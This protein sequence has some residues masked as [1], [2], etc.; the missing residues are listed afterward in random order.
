MRSISTTETL[1][2]MTT[3]LYNVRMHNSIKLQKGVRFGRLVVER[4]NGRSP[5]KEALWL[6]LCDCG[7]KVSIRSRNLRHYTRS[8]G[9]LRDEKSRE[10]MT[11]H[12][13]RNTSTYDTWCGI[14]ARCLN[15]KNTAYNRYGGR[16]ILLCKRWLKFDNFLAD[17]GVKPDGTSI[18]RIDNSKGYSPSN[19][20]WANVS[21]QA[22]NKRNNV[23]LA[24][25][26]KTLT[27]AQWS[28]ILGVKYTTLHMRLFTYG[29]TVD[30]A[31]STPK[32]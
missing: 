9:C 6:C 31:L 27:L 17:M 15:R 14:K 22:N 11:T 26:G 10:R 19:C 25:E 3:C 30:R 18:D 4:E 12:G 1:A 21:E 28:E 20:R 7:N 23:N 13:M 5:D 16:G 8:C 32:V 24:H 29:W 2:C